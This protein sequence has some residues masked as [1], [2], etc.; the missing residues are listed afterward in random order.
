MK[1]AATASPV[2][3]RARYPTHSA[4][5]SGLLGEFFRYHGAW[6]PGVRLFRA[7]GFNAKALIIAAAF[8]VPMALLAW[9]YF[10]AQAASIEFSAKEHLGID[11]ARKVM[12]VLGGLLRLRAEVVGGGAA[13][14][15]AGATARGDPSLRS[16]LDADL[17]RLAEFQEVHADTLTTAGAYDGFVEAGRRARTPAAS[18]AA[19]FDAHSAWIQSLIDLLGVSTDGSNLTLDPDI[20][21]YYLMD[22]SM[23][24]LP[25][26][27]EAAARSGGL[28]AQRAAG[29][30]LDPIRTRQL[31]EQLSLLGSNLGAMQGGLAKAFAY[32]AAVGKD[33]R[34]EEARVRIQALVD[35]LDAFLSKPDASQG[36]ATLGAAVGSDTDAAINA[37]FELSQ[38]ATDQLDALV[39]LRVG[40]YVRDRNVTAVVVA[41]GL[42]LAAYL[43][44]SFRKVLDGGI[45]EIAHH[46]DAMRDGDLTTSPRPWGS[47]EA[48]GLMVS[49]SQM[50]ASLRHIVSLVRSASDSIVGASVQI[51]A[52]AADLSERTEKSAANLEET[53][54]AMEEIASTVRS[55]EATVA[56]ATGLADANA[57]AA[58]RGGEI[59]REVVDTMQRINAA[60]S[61]IVDIIATIDGISFQTNILA[62]NAAVEAARAGEQGR[63]FAVVASEVRELALRAAEASREIKT[64][65]VGSVQQ[66]EGGVQ[67]VRK[68]GDAIGEMVG[69]TQ[70]VSLL[71][72][73][74]ASSAREQ[75]QGIAQS[76]Q[77][78][79]E[80]DNATQQNAALVEQTAAAAASLNEQAMGLASEVS[81]FKLPTD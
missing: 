16:V 14:S 77:A 5:G 22:A 17:A 79:Q 61:R 38:R 42:L 50:Q 76:S 49:M 43:F 36:D 78:V 80:I 60:S 6:A 53:A 13:G 8:V 31:I 63:G 28:V 52:G 9:N 72:A 57:T 27:L 65:I 45:R 37:M 12:P 18:P 29:Q 58:E 20:D 59:I 4:G 64:L 35:T 30:P 2:G 69:T 51:S 71:L 81:R 41:L 47:D 3:K 10:Q 68:A 75:T 39:A 66:V 34:L 62:L 23:F 7:I 24:R 1:T 74:V 46:I 48:A 11:Y 40:K 26:M 56:E 21:T 55:N 54:A 70:R 44:M 67:V 33:T 25:V 19:A 32:N 73:E 15:R